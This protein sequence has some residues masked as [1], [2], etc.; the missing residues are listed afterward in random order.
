M[1]LSR[2]GMLIDDV[3]FEFPMFKLNFEFLV[4]TLSGCFLLLLFF[5][6][7]VATLFFHPRVSAF[8]F[9]NSF[10]IKLAFCSSDFASG[11]TAFGSTFPFHSFPFYPDV[12]ALG[13]WMY[14][15]HIY[16]NKKCFKMNR[17]VCIFNSM[18]NTSNMSPGLQTQ[19][20]L[21]E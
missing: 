15:N 20:L 8:G 2:F 19:R 1:L 16:I 13:L 4:C 12:T 11:V 17:S 14:T 5:S 7:L 6:F 18:F 21:L 3:D 9:C 10:S